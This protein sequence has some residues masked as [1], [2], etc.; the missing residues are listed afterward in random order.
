MT[1]EEKINLLNELLNYEEN[2]DIG[3]LTR[4]ERREF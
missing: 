1:E 4:A 2:N 3:N